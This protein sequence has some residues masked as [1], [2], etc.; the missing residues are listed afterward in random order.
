MLGVIRAL[1]SGLIAAFCRIVLIL[2][3]GVP[4][5]GVAML[6][7]RFPAVCLLVP[8][9][10]AWRRFHRRTV[11]DSYG[12]ATTASPAQME[13][14]GLL[15]DDGLI[16]GRCLADPPSLGAGVGA[17]FSPRT[18]S[19][20]ACRTFLAGLYGGKRHGDRLIRVNQYVHLLTCSPPGGGKSI[21]ALI[22][23][24]RSHRGN[25]VVVDPKGELFRATA[26]HRRRKFGHKIIRLDPFG[27]CGPGGDTLNAFDF[28]DH[29]A[30]DFIDQLRA[31]AD[32][33]VIR[34]QD[35]KDPHWNESAIANV[36]ALS[37]F[38]C[39]CEPNRS[40]RHLGT[41]R[42]LASSRGTYARAVEVMQQTDACQDVIATLGGSLTWHEGEELASV[43]TTLARH[44]NFL[45][46]P[47]VRRNTATSSFDPMILRKGKATVYLILPHDRLSS[48]SRLQRL[49]IGTIMRRITSGTPTEKNPVLWV[50]DEM[51]HIG[52]MQAIEDATTLYRGMGMRLWFIFQSLNQVKTCF[53]EKAATVLD[54]IGTQQF[55]GIN[56]YE[57]AEEISKRI[58][59]TTIGIETETDTSGDSHSSGVT[60]QQQSS[61]RSR[62]KTLNRSEIARRLL[63]PEEVLRL[64]PDVCLIFHK[65]LPV[66]VGRLVKYFNA[67]EFARGGTA[68]TRRMGIA[69]AGTAMFTLFASC[70]VTAVA[71]S[72][73]QPHPWPMRPGA[74]VAKGARPSV[75]PPRQPAS[76]SGHAREL[77]DFRP[78]SRSYAEG[79]PARRPGAGSHR[80]SGESGYLIKIE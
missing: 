26:K 41:M 23:N 25:C 68:A 55:F 2:A 66:C 18:R 65:H 15:C 60:A 79:R 48:L 27:V 64:P 61:S 34:Q 12:S 75:Y 36:A 24:L 20:L 21:A 70:F 22:P 33:M 62:S 53:G 73:A 13:A 29:R 44:T 51:A 4:V 16:L 46:S 57:T 71:L 74:A 69:A 32:D 1:I 37:S 50:L 54:S 45:D 43:Q 31:L 42:K 8:A 38:V 56:S 5:L 78:A 47:V 14:G 49:W 6:A 40:K 76:P 11:T 72:V 28:I 7:L 77:P 59:D 17:L 80:R 67:P 10:M 52:R 63:K 19:D 39:G 58:G 30:D 3:C 35:E 9:Y